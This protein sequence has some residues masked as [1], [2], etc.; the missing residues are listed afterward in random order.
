MT[1]RRRGVEMGLVIRGNGAPA[2]QADP[3]LLKAEARA[4]RWSEDL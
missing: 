3:A 1:I 4:Y 2:R